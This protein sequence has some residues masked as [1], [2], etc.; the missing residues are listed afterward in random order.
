MKD[1]ST[2]RNGG[3][4]GSDQYSKDWRSAIREYTYALLES[5]HATLQNERQDALKK[6]E[7][8]INEIFNEA[9]E[10]FNELHRREPTIDDITELKEI[11]SK[12]F[13]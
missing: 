5:K 10:K 2:G 9:E 4:F 11:I 7:D 12:I 3:I 6:N 8:S 1:N 13:S